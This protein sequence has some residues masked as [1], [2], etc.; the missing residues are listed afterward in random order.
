[1]QTIIILIF[2]PPTYRPSDNVNGRRVLSSNLGGD[3]AIEKSLQ[4]D[5]K[6]DLEFIVDH[7]L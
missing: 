7:V 1:M 2:S 3:Y 6:C 5:R 4:D